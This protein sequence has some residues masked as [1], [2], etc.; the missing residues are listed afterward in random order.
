MASLDY[1]GA[2]LEGTDDPTIVF[3]PKT[4]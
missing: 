3:T 4:P 1:A 2:P